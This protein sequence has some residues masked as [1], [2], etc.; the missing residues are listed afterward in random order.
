MASLKLKYG[1]AD[2]LAQY[3][4]HLAALDRRAAFSVILNTT[5]RLNGET[6]SLKEAFSD[7]EDAFHVTNLILLRIS[8]KKVIDVRM[9]IDD[10]DI[11]GEVY[12]SRTAPF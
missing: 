6:T 8:N 10:E 9:D 11:E 2:K 3:F 1:L 7:I 5:F 12:Y 4:Q